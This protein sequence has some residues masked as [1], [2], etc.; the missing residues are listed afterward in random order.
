[1][2]IVR[3]INIKFLQDLLRRLNQWHDDQLIGDIFLQM[4]PFFK[5]YKEYYNNYEAGLELLEKLA[6]RK[7]VK[8][9]L[10]VC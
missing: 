8:D 2:E 3:S 6:K 9:Y 7:D 4:I 1:M 10:K 5:V